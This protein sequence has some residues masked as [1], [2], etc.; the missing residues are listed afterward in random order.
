[1]GYY[2][3]EQG[4]VYWYDE[5]QKNLIGSKNEMSAEE[6]EAHLNPPPPPATMEQV[7]QR[8]QI[9]CDSIAVAMVGDYKNATEVLVYASMGDVEAKKFAD[10]YNSVWDLKASLEY[11]PQDVDAWIESLP[12]FKEVTT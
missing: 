6:I 10:W 1:M 11:A 3:D 5:D 2:K 8:L 12:K 9:Y 4:S 7:K